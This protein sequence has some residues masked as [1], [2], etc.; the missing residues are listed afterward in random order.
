MTY[1]LSLI[2]RPEPG[3]TTVSSVLRDVTVLTWAVDPARLRPHVP[4][5]FDLELLD[6]AA[7]ISAVT[8][9][10][11]SFRP[12]WLPLGLSLGQTNY[13]VYVQ[14]EG[15]RGVFFVG[16]TIDTPFVGVPRYLWRMPW[17]RA[18][19]RFSPGTVEATGEWSMSLRFATSGPVSSLAGYD[20]LEEGLA[21]LTQPWE[22]YYL[23]TSGRVG[24]YTIWHAPYTPQTA[25]VTEAR[26]SLL[27]ELDIVPFSEQTKLHSAMSEAQTLYHVHLPP[28]WL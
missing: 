13:R 15:R 16:T 19:Y 7:L 24:R 17:R 18:R 20:R 22:G 6:G 14:R 25:T 8:F 11:T 9:F 2:P 23:G 3:W 5:M 26:F 27:D 21:V 28:R 1:E 12:H 10:N 4:E